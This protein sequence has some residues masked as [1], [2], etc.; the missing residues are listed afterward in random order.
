MEMIGLPKIIIILQVII[1]I[2]LIID[3]FYQEE[4]Y[5][6]R[7]ILDHGLSKIDNDLKIVTKLLIKNLIDNGGHGFRIGFTVVQ[8]WDYCYKNKLITRY[9]TSKERE[10]LEKY[11]AVY[12]SNKHMSEWFDSLLAAYEKAL[13]NQ[14]NR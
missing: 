2:T 9:L 8:Y 3:I 5:V 14:E 12:Y 1:I 11:P 13:R 10:I 7:N 4:K 6:P